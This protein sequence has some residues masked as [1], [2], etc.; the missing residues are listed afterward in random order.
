MC[1]QNM[2]RSLKPNTFVKKNGCGKIL[3]NINCVDL[4]TVQMAMQMLGP[5]RDQ[6][7]PAGRGTWGLL[8]SS[9]WGSPLH[10]LWLFCGSFTDREG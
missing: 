10:S 5:V 2:P 7:R 1:L 3:E 4:H 6:L 8:G 9:L